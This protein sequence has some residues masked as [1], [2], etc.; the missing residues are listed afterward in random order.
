VPRVHAEPQ[1]TEAVKNVAEAGEVK[2]ERTERTVRNYT[3]ELGETV[4]SISKMFTNY[5]AS[6]AWADMA[7]LDILKP[8]EDDE[9]K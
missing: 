7:V 9:E 6:R 3:Q 2:A 1:Q 5:A 4:E 8:E